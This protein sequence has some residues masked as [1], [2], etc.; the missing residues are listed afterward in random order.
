MIKWSVHQINMFYRANQVA[1]IGQC[2]RRALGADWALECQEA[3]EL[4]IMT[5][6]LFSMGSG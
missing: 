1:A 3:A 6:L 4:M 5:A 2:V